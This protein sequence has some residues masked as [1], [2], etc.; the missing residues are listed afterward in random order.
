MKADNLSAFIFYVYLKITNALTE[1]LKI[2]YI[3][4]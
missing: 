1:M 2:F 3:Y 4:P